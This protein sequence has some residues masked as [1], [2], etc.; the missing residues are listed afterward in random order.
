MYYPVADEHGCWEVVDMSV[1]AGIDP[2]DLHDY[3][4]VLFTEAE[5]MEEEKGEDNLLPRLE[6][7]NLLAKKAIMQ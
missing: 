2:L 7:E 5:E 1:M 6:L 3:D 4:K